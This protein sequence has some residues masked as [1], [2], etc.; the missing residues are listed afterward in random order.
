VSGIGSV[1]LAVWIALY[2]PDGDTARKALW[3]SFIICL[4]VAAYRIWAT[5]HRRFLEEK[6]KHE[7]HK[8]IFELDEIST[9]VFITTDPA[10]ITARLKL[11][12]HNKEIYDEYLKTIKLTLHNLIDGEIMTWIFDDQ[13]FGFNGS[14]EV[15]I[16]RDGFEGMLIQ[17]K[18]LTPWY[19]CAITIH[20]ASDE[21]LQIPG[22]LTGAHYLAATIDVTNQEL[23]QT[24]IFVDWE[25]ACN[26]NGT[27]VLS[28]GAPAIR[29]FE[30]RRILEKSD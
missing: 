25:K 1:I 11:R 8:V 19:L 6:A 23:Y 20:P 28:Y 24:H 26:K 22:G 14:D 27:A 4:F 18:R 7:R 12:F 2:A 17:G 5:E 29:R 16:P 13:Y 3:L 9:R 10:L 30:D 15:E 21:K